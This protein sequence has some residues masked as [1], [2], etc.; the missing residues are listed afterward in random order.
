MLDAIESFVEQLKH[1]GKF[2]RSSFPEKAYQ[3]LL[4]AFELNKTKEFVT[5]PGC[6]DLAKSTQGHLVVDDTSNPKYG[7]KEVSRKLFIPSTS[8]FRHGYKVLL[9]LWECDLGCFPLGFSLWYRGSSSLNEL[10]LNFIS[11]FRNTF[12]LKP[13]SCL[14]D[15]AFFTLDLAKRLDDYGWGFVM[16]CKKNRQV[17]GQSVRKLIPRGFGEAVGR[18]ANGLAVKVIRHAGHFLITN[19]KLKTRAELQA[20]YKMRWRVEETFRFL[21]SKLAL[22]SCQQHSIKA[23]GVFV[24]LCL[25]TFSILQRVSAGKPYEALSNV[26]SGQFNLKNLNPER[27]FNYA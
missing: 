18:L 16:R 22:K 11:V 13:L 20:L 12:H 3:E 27:L 10:T 1:F 9:L 8:G 7:L 21:K 4:T 23:Q 15:A 19:R 6:L 14:M 17:N 25:L 2:E 26:M 5:F 24:S